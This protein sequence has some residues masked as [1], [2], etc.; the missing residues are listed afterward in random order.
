VLL[1]R[2]ALHAARL[3]LDHPTTGRRM[4]FEAPL[5]P[6]LEAVLAALRR[7]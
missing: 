2:H 6:D 4:T 7:T 3:S 1:A 5:P